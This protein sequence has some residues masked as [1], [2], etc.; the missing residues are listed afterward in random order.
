MA[1]KMLFWLIPNQAKNYSQNKSEFT[2]TKRVNTIH[3]IS[4]L[5]LVSSA[6]HSHQY[7]AGLSVYSHVPPSPLAHELPLHCCYN[8]I[9]LK[10]DSNLGGLRTMW[11]QHHANWARLLPFERYH[12][13]H[14]CSGWLQSG[15]GCD[16]SAGLNEVM[17]LVNKIQK[18]L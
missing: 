7:S 10:S 15:L 12:S 8:K 14:Q 1:A 5:P 17:N 13:S 3:F 4:T 2:Y 16:D 9:N 18:S 6:R 11:Y